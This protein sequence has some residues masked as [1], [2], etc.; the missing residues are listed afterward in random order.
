ML[1]TGKFLG[2]NIESYL[3][4]DGKAF[5]IAIK[6]FYI[7]KISIFVIA[8]TKMLEAIKNDQENWAGRAGTSSLT[9]RIRLVSL[10][11]YI[12]GN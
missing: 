7:F 5:R 2:L 9:K 12:I 10:K 3:S 4:Y 8:H 6:L 11:N 1:E